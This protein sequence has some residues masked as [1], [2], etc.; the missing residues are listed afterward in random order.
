MVVDEMD[1]K[2]RDSLVHV[3]ISHV[4]EAEM[5][6]DRVGAEDAANSAARLRHRL[7]GLLRHCTVS[8]AERD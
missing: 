1:D 6:L 8:E 5:A 4:L 3:A 7:Y 2:M